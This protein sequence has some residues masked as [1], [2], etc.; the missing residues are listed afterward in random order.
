MYTPPSTAAKRTLRFLHMNLI[1]PER[2]AVF[3]KMYEEE[4]RESITEGQAE[5]MMTGCLQ[6][7]VMLA[8]PLPSERLSQSEEAASSEH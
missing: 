6:L 1:N 3:A 5:V 7:L 2:V 4:F 8:K